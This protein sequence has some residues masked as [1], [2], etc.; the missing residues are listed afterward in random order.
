MSVR[1]T[2]RLKKLF[3]V[4]NIGFL[5]LIGWICI[6]IGFFIIVVAICFFGP[7]NVNLDFDSTLLSYYGTFVGG[8]AGS[9]L[10]VAG[11]FILIATLKETQ[12]NSKQQFD[13]IKHQ[14]FENIFFDLLENLRNIVNNT[15]HGTI[16]I[17]YCKGHTFF[18]VANKKLYNAINDSLREKDTRDKL[19]AYQGSNDISGI[20][21][22]NR[23]C[24]KKAYDSFFD[25]YISQLGHY[26]RFLFNLLKFVEERSDIKNKDFYINFIQ[27]QMSSDELALTFYNG[28]GKYGKKFY[29]LIEK[30]NFLQNL[31]LSR[32]VNPNIHHKFYPNS[33]FRFLSN[34][35]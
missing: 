6:G 18:L 17:D 19:G 31:D 29:D 13:I 7:I 30:Y 28:I 35:S 25:V 2:D 3:A 5:E 9:I 8:L 24:A 22:L 21:E 32:I 20:L 1:N 16:G 34:Q 12:R 15:E 26:F 10:S 33:K 23:I 11:V 4:K 14:Q 27:A